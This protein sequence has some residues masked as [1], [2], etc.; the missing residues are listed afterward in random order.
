MFKSIS[1]IQPMKKGISQ[2]VSSVLMIAFVVAIG[3][4]VSQWSDKLISGSIEKSQVKIGSD[5]ECANVNLRIEDD[6]DITNGNKVIIKNNNMEKLDIK[7]FITRFVKKDETV[8]VDYAH[9]EE[10]IKS[11][12]ANILDLT[13]A[14]ESVNGESL[15][16]D[17]SQVVQ[18][19]VIPRVDIGGEVVNCEN[20][21]V[22]FRLNT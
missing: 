5:L 2:M 13:S 7:G 6:N 1:S 20:K 18:I 22:K 11:F 3:I 9:D 15:N 4:A 14:K 21:K 17:L 19:E 8:S 10:S 12:G 16:V